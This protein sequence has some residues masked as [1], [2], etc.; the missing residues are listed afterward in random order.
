MVERF[1]LKGKCMRDLNRYVDKFGLIVQ[2]VNGNTQG[3]GG[4]SCHKT[5]HLEI[6][7]TLM[8]EPPH[9]SF[10]KLKDVQKATPFVRHPDPSKWYSETNRFS[11]DQA[12]P[13][14]IALALN[15]SYKMLFHFFI[16]HMLHGFLF[17]WN[18]VPNWISSIGAKKKMPDITFAEFFNIYIRGFRL[19]PL[20]PMLLL[21]DLEMLGGVIIKRFDEDIDVANG[22]ANVL[23]AQQVMPTPLSYLARKILK[24]VAQKKLDAY[25]KEWNME[26]PLN[27]Y[28]KPVVD[29]M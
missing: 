18:T 25:F 13:Y 23:L 21:G 24:P 19:Y 4:D 15:K 5:S 26:P 27:E 6:A 2:D 8:H 7:L 22:L 28:Y 14:V 16:R 11:R 3:D 1:P 10:E 29:K 17:T 9:P 12:T 20:Y